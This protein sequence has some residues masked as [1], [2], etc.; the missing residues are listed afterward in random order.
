M[1]SFFGLVVELKKVKLPLKDLL[2]F[3]HV[4]KTFGVFLG[5]K[6]N[7]VKVKVKIVKSINCLWFYNSL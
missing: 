7:F 1:C 6:R 2:H 5:L 3:S 4:V